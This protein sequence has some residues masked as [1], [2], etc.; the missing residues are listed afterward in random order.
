DTDNVVVL[1]HVMIKP[2]DDTPPDVDA[3]VEVI[4]KTNQGY[5]ATPSARIPFSG[6]VRDDHGLDDVAYAYTLLSLDAQAT[7]AVRP[8][9]SALQWLP[10][11]LG[12]DV[13]ATAYLAWLGTGAGT[14]ADDSSLSPEK[15]PLAAFLR[16][17]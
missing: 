17:V 15:K 11:G 9:V 8:V 16:A 7:V 4:R 3:V 5:L 10:R 1:R 2:I 13:L 6:K 12:P 14:A